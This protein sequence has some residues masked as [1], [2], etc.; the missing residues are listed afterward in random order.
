MD[1]DLGVTVMVDEDDEDD[2]EG[3]DLD[4][5]NDDVDPEEM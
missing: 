3:S 1:E 2:A 5:V 4:E